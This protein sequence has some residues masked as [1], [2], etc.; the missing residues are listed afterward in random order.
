MKLRLFFFINVL[1]LMIFGSYSTYADEP[2]LIDIN[3]SMF[4]D[5]PLDH[6]NYNAIYYLKNTDVVQGDSGQNL[7][8]PNYR[9]DDDVN[10]AEFLKIIMEGNDIEVSE[11]ADPC[12][13]DVPADEWYSKYVCTAENQ[14]WVYGYPDGYFRPEKTINEVE[15]LKI[16]GEVLDWEKPELPDDAEWYEPYLIPAQE[17]KIV[18]K[19]DIAV[20]MTRGDM[21]E[22][23]YRNTTVEILDVPYFD[24][25]LNPIIF[26]QADIPLSG[27]LG[28]GG[29][30]GP[31]GP[32]G[33]SGAFVDGGAFDP[34]NGA[35][36][37]IPDSFYTE[38]YCYF[39]D[40]GE[41][42]GSNLE[43][44]EDYTQEDLDEFVAGGDIEEFGKMFCYTGIAAT[45]LQHFD[46]Q[47]RA[48]FDVLCWQMPD[49]PSIAEDGWGELFCWA[50]EK[51]EYELPDFSDI[52]QP[53]ISIEVIQKPDFAV[54]YNDSNIEIFRF[55]LKALGEKEMEVFGIDLQNYGDDDPYGMR[56]MMV[57]D[58]DG[59]VYFDSPIYM[60][61]WENG[62]LKLSFD[63]AVLIPPSQELLMSV[64][65]DF[66]WEDYDGNIRIGFW[67]KILENAIVTILGENVLGAWIGI[68]EEL[69]AGDEEQS[70]S[71]LL[72]GMEG[73]GDTSTADS[74]EK[75]PPDQ[76]QLNPSMH[77]VVPIFQ[78]GDTCAAAATY[79]S[80]RWLEKIMGIEGLIHDGQTGYDEWIEVL[81]SG[82]YTLH[83]QYE[84]L[85][86]YINSNFPG[87]L[88]AD[89]NTSWGWGNVTCAELKQYFD[90]KPG[91]DI[92]IGTQCTDEGD[93]LWWGHRVDIVNV[94]IDPENPHKCEL[95]FA[96]SQTGNVGETQG[97]EFDGLG[98]GSYQ[99]GDFDD[100]AN[101]FKIKAP[102]GLNSDCSIYGATFIC[103]ENEAKC[104]E[105]YF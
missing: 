37:L 90:Y 44:L 87:C 34:E 96:N 66:D 4:A 38:N 93:L 26:D 27:P 82:T 12:F 81:Y 75:P 28:P 21:A 88:K 95:I 8:I 83:R 77:L 13:P 74:G 92:E 89:Y 72:L 47:L 52:G 103:I 48:Q 7:D 39:S 3:N 11:P 24:P 32:M 36:T 6:E 9:P 69:D 45:D 58:E 10:R 102:W 64:Y 55:K 40:E 68:E 61:D 57:Q 85:K 65:A 22:L 53:Q 54:L 19:E 98:Y 56:R 43:F 63:S 62:V 33:P 97:E 1:F 100:S 60:T 2:T 67:D 35:V 101:E 20:E 31:G 86:A 17:M 49:L 14:G 91:C 42:S 41:F 50:R 15:S 84:A 59:N 18:P 16:L 73:A 94:E 104:M 29:L 46:E 76:V 30:L 23:V 105:T 71:C 51:E 79:S 25:Q 78:K 80:M 99:R 70:S 5:V